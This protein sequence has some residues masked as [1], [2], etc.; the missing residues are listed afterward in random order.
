ML[1]RGGP[2]GL[3]TRS[4]EGTSDLDLLSIDVRILPGPQVILNLHDGLQPLRWPFGEVVE[5]LVILVTFNRI[6]PGELRCCGW[7]Q[8]VLCK[9]AKMSYHVG[10]PYWE[11]SGKW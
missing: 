1:H 9:L 2:R 3:L 11:L 10:P 7:T 4:A 8:S 5:A 6:K